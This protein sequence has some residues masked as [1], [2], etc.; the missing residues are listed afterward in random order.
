MKPN[1]AQLAQTRKKLA[2]DLIVIRQSSMRA[3]NQGDFRT[4]GKLTME[5]ARLNQA[6][7]D[8]EAEE[9]ASL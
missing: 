6:I 8:L 2:A 1:L 7:S 4:V 3:G 9:L 5:A